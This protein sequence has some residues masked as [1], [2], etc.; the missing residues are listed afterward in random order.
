MFKNETENQFWL[1][2]VESYVFGIK[3]NSFF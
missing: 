1:A 3:F 2:W